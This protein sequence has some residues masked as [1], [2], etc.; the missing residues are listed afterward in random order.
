MARPREEQ[1][2][3]FRCTNPFSVFRRGIPEVY[4]A[5]E[6]VLDDNPILKT[7]RDHFEPAAER[8][9]RR[10]RVEQATAA[11]NELRRVT[12]VEQEPP[13]G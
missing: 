8:V 6:E 13:N 10:T 4:G 3:L 12:T 9:L 5:G 7:H 11:P 1:R 2:Q